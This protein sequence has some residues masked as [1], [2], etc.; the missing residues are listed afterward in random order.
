MMTLTKRLLGDRT[1]RDQ[2]AELFE[3]QRLFQQ[4]FQMLAK[5]VVDLHDLCLM[6]VGIFCGPRASEVLGL[7]WKSWTGTT[8]VPHGTAFEGRFIPADSKTIRAGRQSGSGTGE[9][10]HRGMEEDVS[11]SIAGRSDV[12]DLRAWRAERPGCAALGEELPPVAPH[13]VATKLKIPES[14]VTFQVM[15]RTLGTNLQRHGTL[16]DAQ[17]ALRQA[18]IRTTRT[19][20]ILADWKPTI[21]DGE[22]LTA[23]EGAAPKRRT[24]KLQ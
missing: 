20:E 11:G 23:I 19:L 4:F 1:G 6:Y 7:Q 2:C 24:L 8:L 22:K 12:S 21:L 10:D 13:P 5:N 18:S 15:R 14:L 17:G 16:K 9:T 3:R